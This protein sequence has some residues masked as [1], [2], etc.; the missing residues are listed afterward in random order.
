MRLEQ[1][2]RRVLGALVFLDATTGMRI[3]S[4]LK[5]A[6]QGVRFVRNRSGAYVIFSAPGL[7]A[8]TN[9]FRQQ[10]VAPDPASVALE[11]VAIEISVTDPNHNYLPRRSTI[12][13]PLDPAT[14]RPNAGAWLFAPLE[15][16]LFPSPNSSTLPG[17]A[18]IRA[19]IRE[20]GK[21]DRLPFSLIKVKRQGATGLLA[22]GLADRRGE[23]LVAVPGLPITTS[24]TGTGTVLTSDIAVTLE[25]IYD[26]RVKKVRDPEDLEALLLSPEDYIPDPSALETGQ[27]PDFQS[28]TADTSLA[29]GKEHVANLAVKLT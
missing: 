4:S 10:P 15:V 9:A 24:D 20:E 17:W 5:V 19:T 7:R 28:G 25:V 12:S 13:L 14:T 3:Q 6:A 18:V 2:E 27:P 23:A 1:V 11:T 8:Y 16:R 21:T 29:S 26:T 22:T